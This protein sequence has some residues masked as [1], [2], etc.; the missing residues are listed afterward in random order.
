MP[1]W[2]DWANWAT[3]AVSAACAVYSWIQA[4]KCGKYASRLEKFD[5]IDKLE[6]IKTSCKMA[7][8][9]IE[10]YGPGATPEK[11]AGLDFNQSV[12]A[13]RKHLV[14]VR[15]HGH[16]L[17]E[18]LLDRYCHTI[19]NALGNADRNPIFY[20][21]IIFRTTTEFMTDIGKKKQANKN[22]AMKG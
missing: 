17:D 5:E 3:G 7:L 16:F 8:A 12:E 21:D 20:G 9:A 11:V 13:V 15:E 18:R 1:D 14:T 4:R 19:E 22:D 6:T 2:F 10:M